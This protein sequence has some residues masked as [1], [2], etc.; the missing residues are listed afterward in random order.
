MITDLYCEGVA[1]PIPF[2]GSPADFERIRD[3]ARQRSSTRGKPAMV[4]SWKMDEG[5]SVVLD[6]NCT[7]VIAMVQR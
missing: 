5:L 7:R 3:D 2:N 4:L 1:D 6:L